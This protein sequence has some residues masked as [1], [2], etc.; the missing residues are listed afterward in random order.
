MFQLQAKELATASNLSF[1][2]KTGTSKAA[3]PADTLRV[4]LLTCS[5]GEEIY[6][7]YGHT[8]IRVQESLTG[9]DVLFKYGVVNFNCAHF[10]YP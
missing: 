9:N 5:P 8:A 7:L 4:S 2:Q 6:E 3:L 10:F 1:P